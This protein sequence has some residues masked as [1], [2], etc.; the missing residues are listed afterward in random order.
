MKHLGST[1]SRQ[2]KKTNRKTSSESPMK[3]DDLGPSND[4]DA[5][6]AVL[7]GLEDLRAAT[8]VEAA[9]FPRLI[10]PRKSKQNAIA[11]CRSQ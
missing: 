5:I 11:Y 4:L 8:Y 1:I 9:Q 3:A 2:I 7:P 6:N 10:D